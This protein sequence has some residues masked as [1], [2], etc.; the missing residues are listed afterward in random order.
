MNIKPQAVI[1][2]WRTLPNTFEVNVW[3][4]ETKAGSM[5][6]NIFKNSFFLMRF[7][8][9][10]STPWAPRKDRKTHPLLRETGSMYNSI[11]WKRQN[12]NGKAGKGVTIYTDPDG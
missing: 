5:A 11:K 3:N 10:G 7:N 8:S 4:F 6:T 2:Q 9:S 1:A 12:S